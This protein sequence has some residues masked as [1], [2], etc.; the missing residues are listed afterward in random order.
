M[1]SQLISH[2]FTTFTSL[3][4]LNFSF[5][6]QKIWEKEISMI[7]P[8]STSVVSLY[9]PVFSTSPVSCPGKSGV[10]VYMVEVLWTATLDMNNGIKSV[11]EHAEITLT[12]G[13][14]ECWASFHWQ[15]S[16]WETDRPLPYWETDR[17]LPYW[18]TDRLLPYWEMGRSYWEMD[19]KLKQLP[20]GH[21]R[22]IFRVLH[23]SG[24][25]WGQFAPY[26]PTLVCRD[27]GI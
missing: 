25:G 8:A 16:C 20:C 17:L 4:G 5:F 24:R 15:L 14:Q 9:S 11:E 27:T 2:G 26:V 13:I 12:G 19:V 10:L 3:L 7:P 18:E 23:S 1:E 21:T 22:H 6:L